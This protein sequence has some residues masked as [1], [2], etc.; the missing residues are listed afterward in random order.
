MPLLAAFLLAAA[1][2]CPWQAAWTSSQMTPDANN[3]LPEGA[4][5]DTT[6]RQ[7]VRVSAAGEAVRVRVSNAFGRAP[8]T[9]T[10]ATLARSADNASARLDT[11]TLRALTFSGR[12][13]VTIPAGAEW[14]SDPVTLP[15]RAFDDL[16]VSLRL[17]GDAQGQTSHPGSRATS[18]LAPGD[19]VAAADLPGATTA[20]HWFNLSGVEVRRCGAGGVVAL[21]DSITDGYGVQPNRNERW[22]DFLSRR[23]GGRV[24]VVNQGIGGNRLL[25]DGL[26]PNA[27][28]RLDRDVLAQPGVRHLIVLEGVNDIGQLARG[29]VASTEGRRALVAGVTGAYAQI[30]A[31]A[32]ARGLKVYGGTILPFANTR[33]Y[34]NNPDDADRQAINAWIRTPGH[35]DAVIDFD[36]AMR[37]P[38]VPER[39]NP[40]YDS[41][42]HLHPSVAGYRA[43]AEAVPLA[44]FR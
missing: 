27:L 19:R 17:T 25:R 3:A 4:L 5:A 33:T 37:D 44:L 31:R 15:V 24:A 36:R 28:A 26:G 7:V 39:L 14:L 41:G 35:F 23:L 20:T 13:G 10:A 16:A 22:T 34:G 9:V 12:A 42:D 40:A 30:V 38:Q 2:A 43:M 6:L 32:R 29:G 1:P 8:L 11:A 21:G 18:Y